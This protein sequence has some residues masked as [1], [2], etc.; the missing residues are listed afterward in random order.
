MGEKVEKVS[1]SFLSG[2]V[3]TGTSVLP[4]LTRRIDS[5]NTPATVSGA[6]ANYTA[7]QIAR[8]IILRD[9]SAGNRTDTLPSAADI[10]AGLANIYTLAQNE[11]S[12]V[13]AVENTGANTLTLAAGANTTLQ[14]DFVIPASGYRLVTVIRNT[15]TTV[16]ATVENPL[17]VPGSVPVQTSNI[18]A[19][20]NQTYSAAQLLGG[21]ITRDP[22]GAPRTDVTATGA[23]I[24]TARTSLVVGSYFD[25]T[26]KNTAGA[27]NAVTLNGGV[28][29]TLIS[30]IVVAQ[31]ETAVLRFIKTGTATYDV[32]KLG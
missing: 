25:V 24:D 31:N 9:T 2:F 1:G 21:Y 10:I 27:A 4:R 26:L 23:Q 8:G 18:T 3:V 13:F 32:V 16:V 15:S 12:I 6:N 20:S 19:A 14:G 5:L 17:A 28:G 29:V 7:A 30:A 11:D 22:A